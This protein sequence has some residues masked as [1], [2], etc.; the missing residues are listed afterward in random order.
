MH[1]LIVLPAEVTFQPIQTGLRHSCRQNT[2]KGHRPSLGTLPC[3]LQNASGVDWY[4]LLGLI[5]LLLFQEGVK[6]HRKFHPVNHGEAVAQIKGVCFRKGPSASY[7]YVQKKIDLSRPT[8]NGTYLASQL[9]RPSPCR[10]GLQPAPLWCLQTREIGRECSVPELWPQTQSKLW[11]TAVV[12]VYIRKE[13]GW[14]RQFRQFRQIRRLYQFHRWCPASNPSYH[15]YLSHPPL[16][17]PLD[18]GKWFIL[19]DLAS[20][21]LSLL[22]IGCLPHRISSVVLPGRLSSERVSQG[23]QG[24]F[25]SKDLCIELMN[26]RNQRLEKQQ[27]LCYSVSGIDKEE[28]PRLGSTP[29]GFLYHF[30]KTAT[31]STLLIW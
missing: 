16:H 24:L 20:L 22:G 3:G 13:H 23:I 21:Y 10:L 25:F 26:R 7:L 14:L 1:R 8:A 30:K 4:F 27:T 18:L 19:L 9:L 11:D 29:Q 17:T 31:P 12:W 5:H 6:P 28:K 15:I 2:T